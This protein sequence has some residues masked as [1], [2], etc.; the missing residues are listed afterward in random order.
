MPAIKVDSRG[1]QHGVTKAPVLLGENVWLHVAGLCRFTEEADIQ[2]LLL[3]LASPW[4]ANQCDVAGF[5]DS[6]PPF[7]ERR[8]RDQGR[9]THGWALLR[10]TDER[11][12]QS[13]CA[14]LCGVRVAPHGPLELSA[15]RCRVQHSAEKQAELQAVAQAKAARAEEQRQHNARQRQR[16]KERETAALEE[17]L[18][19]LQPLG[20]G[21]CAAASFVGL[22]N[23]A[24]DWPG[25]DWTQ[26]PPSCCPD[27]VL[28]NHR[29]AAGLPAP[30][31]T[32]EAQAQRLRRKRVQVESF[33]CVLSL[34]LADCGDDAGMHVVDFGCGTGGLV[35]PLAALFPRCRFTAVDLDAN[36]IGILER[37]AAAAGLKNIAGCVSRIETYTEAFDIAV[38]LHCCGAAT[39]YAQLSAIAQRA[40][41]ILCPCCVGK[42]VLPQSQKH[43]KSG[44]GVAPQLSHPRSAW[45]RA[46]CDGPTFAALAAAADVSHSEESGGGQHP[47]RHLHVSRLCALNM[48]LDRSHA[49]AEA[50]YECACLTLFQPTIQSKNILLV[51]VPNGRDG[52]AHTIAGIGKQTNGAIS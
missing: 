23:I 33:A 3:A 14:A 25:L 11:S 2:S 20:G 7:R 50:G 47:Q 9:C 4:G 5:D 41:Y 46:A 52:W 29:Q 42:V 43:A 44:A 19:R 22:D 15:A 17:A 31:A 49:A 40:A 45:M 26:V 24:S 6:G 27:A 37:R 48:A 51:G 34:L 39:D 16:R 13:A 28:S 1:R 38:G 8:P 10:F 30:V 36:S 32:E 21:T 12:A 35:L 18:E